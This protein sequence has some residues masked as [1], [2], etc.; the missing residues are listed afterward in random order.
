MSRRRQHQ[1][2]SLELLLDT[3]CNAF[4]GIIM[5]ALLIAL[6]S[7]DA[8]SE[9]ATDHIQR[10]LQSIEQQT[11]EAQQLQQ[12]L[13]ISEP[14]TTAAF[15]LLTQRDELRQRIEAAR[16]MIR[17]NTTALAAI[18]QIDPAE[19]ERLVAQLQ[20]KT[21]DVQTLQQQIE[22]EMQARQRALR[23]PRE[24]ATGKKT[25]YFIV[26]FGRIYPVHAMRDGRRELNTQ[27][28]DW[29]HAEG[30]ET[31]VPKAGL[32]FDVPT[33]TR[34]FAEIPSN[35]YSIHFIVYN[36]SF[37]MFLAARQVPVSRNYD[38]GWEFLP[39]DRPIIFSS[40]GEAPPAL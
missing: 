2:D 36:D 11:T 21:N 4:G 1:P 12:R 20:S 7:R 6:L 3:M 25:Y 9:T 39:E 22:R 35:T 37:P 14:N 5:I 17:S 32:G 8:S 16:H 34:L 23:L 24:R 13:K 29:R 19:T 27:T 40:R 33:F 28:L 10:L 30:G 26:R 18:P 38:T 15:E 31:A